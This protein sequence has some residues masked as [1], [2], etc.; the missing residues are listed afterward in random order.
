MSLG[1]RVFA[2]YRLVTFGICFL[3]LC[4]SLAGCSI[5]IGF[6]VAISESK[7]AGK[8]KSLTEEVTLRK[9]IALLGSGVKFRNEA[10]GPKRE[11]LSK[12]P[13]FVYRRQFSTN[14]RV[15]PVGL[16]VWIFDRSGE[17]IHKIH[18]ATITQIYNELYRWVPEQWSRMLEHSPRREELLRT[19][20]DIFWESLQQHMAERIFGDYLSDPYLLFGPSCAANKTDSSCKGLGIADAY[21]VVIRTFLEAANDPLNPVTRTITYEV[22]RGRL[23]MPR[24]IL[25]LDVPNGIQ[26]LSPYRET[27]DFRPEISGKKDIFEKIKIFGEL[28]S[29]RRQRYRGEHYPDYNL[30]FV[31]LRHLLLQGEVDNPRE[32][33]PTKQYSNV[34]DFKAAF[35]L[36]LSKMRETASSQLVADDLQSYLVDKYYYMFGDNLDAYKSYILS[37]SIGIGRGLNP[38]FGRIELWGDER[39][40]AVSDQ[41][42]A[43]KTT[44]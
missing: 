41:K 33:G 21:R 3:A 5:H 9:E 30:L 23:K 37:S 16:E 13:P 12:K 19:K 40:V 36:L 39:L 43:S 24:V 38:D 44:R 22:R 28:P 2:V 18:T 8:T 7:V 35:L 11:S 4:Q 10:A 31:P 32:R 25:E 1:L 34:A 17:P 42:S 20:S 14:S 15:S 26:I 29:G 6:P 27:L